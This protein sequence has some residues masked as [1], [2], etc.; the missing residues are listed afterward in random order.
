MQ[1]TDLLEVSSKF[2]LHYI[3]RIHG[4]LYEKSLKDNEAQM[5]KILRKCQ[6]N[7]KAQI[8]RVSAFVG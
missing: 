7:H 2:Q 8:L 4:F 5:V 6:E 1:A 3:A